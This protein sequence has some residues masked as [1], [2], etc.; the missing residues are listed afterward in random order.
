M[1]TLTSNKSREPPLVKRFIILGAA[2]FLIAMILIES[3]IASA[4]MIFLLVGA[5]PGTSIN[6]SANTMLVIVGL[7]TWLVLLRGAAIGALD[8]LT[9]KRLV[10][11]HTA[12]L[13]R[14]PKR[15][16]SRI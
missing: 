16:Y 9:M 5:I 4:L 1:S 8:L 15:R 12:R 10:R 2:F 13:E 14:R 7:V 6:I 3:G 11:K